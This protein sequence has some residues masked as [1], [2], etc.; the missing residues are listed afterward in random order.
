MSSAYLHDMTRQKYILFPDHN[1]CL[2]GDISSIINLFM[3]SGKY[4]TRTDSDCYIR[5]R[6]DLYDYNRTLS[7]ADLKR[8]E[9]ISRR[10][11]EDFDLKKKQEELD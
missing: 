5:D 7:R 4:N 9:K 3:V 6:G 1:L 10:Q 8:Q 2:R 11:N